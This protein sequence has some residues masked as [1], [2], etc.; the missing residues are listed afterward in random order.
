MLRDL[1]VIYVGSP[2]LFSRGASAIHVMK[3]CQAMARLGATVELILPSYKIGMNIFE[4]YDVEPVFTIKTFPSTNTFARHIL[5]GALSA[6]YT[7]KNKKNF[8]FILTRNI[9]YTYLSTKF[10]KIPTIYDAH[11]PLVNNAAKFLFKSFKDSRYLIRFSTNTKGL[12]EIYKK[13]GLPIDKLVVAHNGVDLESFRKNM[14][15]EEARKNLG[16]PIKKKIVC[17]SGNIYSGRGIE[18]LID[19]ATRLKDVLFIVAGGLEDDIRRCSEIAIAKGAE[20]FKLIGF[21]PHKEV[22]LY[23]YSADVLVI[24]YTSLMTIKGGTRAS[25]FTSPIKLFE[26]MAS[27][28]PI[29]ATSLPTIAEILVND[30]NSVLVEPNSVDLLFKGIKRVLE[31]RELAKNISIQAAKDVKK[32]TWEQRVEKIFNGL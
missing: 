17:Y 26:Y 23:V 21:V 6:Y 9:F 28:R 11:H 1:R 30:R 24:P 7:S 3:M 27:R 31:D 25:E 13:E 22:P 19:V 29:V 8:D 12:G 15:K 5:H 10:F 20:N 16:L 14:S 2:E 32:Y 18:L 4:Y